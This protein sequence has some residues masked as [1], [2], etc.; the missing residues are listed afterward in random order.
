MTQE[1]SEQSTP[2][3]KKA[4]KKKKKKRKKGNKKKLEKSGDA[5]DDETSEEEVITDKAITD[6]DASMEKDMASDIST[7]TTLELGE[8]GESIPVTPEKQLPTQ[9]PVQQQAE[10]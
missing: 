1:T 5:A 3:T 9:P 2:G 4:R 8:E 7:T 6:R 10:E